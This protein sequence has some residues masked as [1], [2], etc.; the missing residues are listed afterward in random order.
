MQMR[1]HL[2]LVHVLALTSGNRHDHIWHMWQSTLKQKDKAQ[3]LRKF[4]K[5]LAANRP[6]SAFK[7]QS[8]QSDRVKNMLLRVSK[9][10]STNS[11]SN[12][13][14]VRRFSWNTT[15]LLSQSY[16]VWYPQSNCLF[17]YC[18]PYTLKHY[19]GV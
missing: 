12:E 1:S 8:E 14:C 4:K 3:R 5:Q 16:H 6:Y 18:Q 2:H 19:I 9:L 17:Y 15:Y 13:K 10:F 11:K 7:F